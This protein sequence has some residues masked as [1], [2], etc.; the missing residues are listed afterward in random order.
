[1][2]KDG[3]GCNRK[4]LGARRGSGRGWGGTFMCV[5]RPCAVRRAH[6]RALCAC[7]CG[8]SALS[9]PIVASSTRNRQTELGLLRQLCALVVGYSNPN[10]HE[11]NGR[12]LPGRTEPFSGYVLGWSFVCWAPTNLV[13]KSAHHVR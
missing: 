1:M 9:R 11:A 4:D 8:S 10:C 2:H 3:C 5:R 7:I 6:I 13:Q 12:A